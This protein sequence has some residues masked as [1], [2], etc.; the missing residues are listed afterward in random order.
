[1]SHHQHYDVI[2]V[3]SGPAGSTAALHLA[4]GG[5]RVS[6]V[7]KAELP[8]YKTCGGG[9]VRRAANLLPHDF[10]LGSSCICQVVGLGE[11]LHG[12]ATP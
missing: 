7:E 10:D 6:L 1:M 9:I 2:V 11:S 4:Q 5:A 8:R 3:G 12:G